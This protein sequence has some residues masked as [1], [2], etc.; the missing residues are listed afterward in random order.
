MIWLQK[1]Q[2]YVFSLVF[3]ISS[4]FRKG[5]KPKAYKNT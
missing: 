4:Q 3:W 1:R 2:I 5:Y